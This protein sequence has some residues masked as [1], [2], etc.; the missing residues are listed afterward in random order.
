MAGAPNS[1]AFE[2]STISR[3]RFT[4]GLGPEAAA[5]HPA[6]SEEANLCAD[7]YE[8]HISFVIHNLPRIS[9]LRRTT[10]KKWRIR[11]GPPEDAGADGAAQVA[12]KRRRGWPLTAEGRT[13]APRRQRA[14]KRERPTGTACAAVANFNKSLVLTFLRCS[15]LPHLPR[16]KVAASTS[17]PQRVRGPRRRSRG[18]CCPPL[19]VVVTRHATA[20]ARRRHRR[21]PEQVGVGGGEAEGRLGRVGG[22]AATGSGSGSGRP[23]SKAA[24]ARTTIPL[25]PDSPAAFGL[26]S[27]QRHL[28]LLDRDVQLLIRRRYSEKD[29]QSTKMMRR[30]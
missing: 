22:S 30:P 3:D 5:S 6:S 25:L 15:R 1:G 4:P 17:W 19:R 12:R 11:S 29:Q 26:T 24:E 9:P 27:H 23:Q 14:A 20:R 2:T 8:R 28:V 7:M 21:C 16:P 13:A 18:C 10:N